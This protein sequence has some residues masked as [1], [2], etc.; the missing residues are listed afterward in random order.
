MKKNSKFVAAVLM[1]ASASFLL[2]GCHAKGSLSSPVTEDSSS[3]VTYNSAPLL[4]SQKLLETGMP[5]SISSTDPA[6]FGFKTAISI[7]NL[8]VP[9]YL[10]TNAPT[11]D[12]GKYTDLTGIITFRGNNYRSN[13]VFGTASI[14]EKKF[15]LPP[16]VGI[17]MFFLQFHTKNPLPCDPGKGF[18]DFTLSDFTLSISSL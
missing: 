1:A 2:T 6:N 7:N 3:Q 8:I 10:D 15:P 17:F 9:N 16:K 14:T 11:F 18:S 5:V 12:D 4:D 13:P